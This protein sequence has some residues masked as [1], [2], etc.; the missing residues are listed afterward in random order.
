MFTNFF[1]CIKYIYNSIVESASI[2]PMENFLKWSKAHGKY[3]T[4]SIHRAQET[5]WIVSLQ[6]WTYE[7][8]SKMNC[9]TPKPNR[10]LGNFDWV[11][12]RLK[13]PT[14][15]CRSLNKNRTFN[16]QSKPTNNKLHIPATSIKLDVF[17]F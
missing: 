9:R 13:V 11:V 12:G 7:N 6:S 4:Y 10:I 1:L 8:T 3:Q 15:D 14:I 5:Q 17:V 16:F 2:Q